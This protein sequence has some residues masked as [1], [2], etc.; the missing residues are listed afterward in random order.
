MG[1]LIAA[2]I[3]FFILKNGLPA[4][5]NIAANTLQPLPTAATP[6]AV[7]TVPVPVDGTMQTSELIASNNL[8]TPITTTQIPT[9]PNSVGIPSPVSHPV[10]G[11]PVRVIGSFA[12]NATNS[13]G[14]FNSSGTSIELGR[15]YNPRQIQRL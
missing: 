4:N 15:S 12:M 1:Y 9:I 3:G 13:G 5:F 8:A 10:K 6:P 2:V 7:A 11:T 14:L